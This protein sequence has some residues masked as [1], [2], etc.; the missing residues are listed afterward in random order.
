MAFNDHHAGE[1]ITQ[2]QDEGQTFFLAGKRMKIEGVLSTI[3]DYLNHAPP[4]WPSP[5]QGEGT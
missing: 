2:R 4:S 1:M 3:L 5:F